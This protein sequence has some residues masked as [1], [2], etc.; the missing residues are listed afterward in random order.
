MIIGFLIFECSILTVVCFLLNSRSL[1][2]VMNHLGGSA[3][4][5]ETGAQHLT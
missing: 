4:L 2:N 5:V 1:I 3:G